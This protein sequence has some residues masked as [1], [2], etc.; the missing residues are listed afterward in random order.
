MDESVVVE[1]V[2]LVQIEIPVKTA[3]RSLLVPKASPASLAAVPLRSNQRLLVLLQLLGI[4]SELAVV[5]VV[6]VVGGAGKVIVVVVV[7][8]GWR[9]CDVRID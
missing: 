2:A 8:M 1:T 7:T 9:T 4:S 3:D 6:V 5:V